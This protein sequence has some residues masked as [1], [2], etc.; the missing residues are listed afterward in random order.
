[1]SELILLC[2]PAEVDEVRRHGFRVACA[3]WQAGGDGRLWRCPLPELPRGSLMAVFGGAGENE[4]LGADIAAECG[5]LGIN[6]VLHFAEAPLRAAGG[7]KLYAPVSTAISGGSL[8]QRFDGEASAFIEPVREYFTLPARCGS[9]RQISAAQLEKFAAGACCSGF[10]PELGC[11]YTFSEAGCV[12][13]DDA[14]TVRRK[15]E[16]LGNIGVERIVLPYASPCVRE[17]LRE[18]R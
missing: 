3:A 14:E 12:L 4:R 10:S 18:C 17:F 5:R 6:E 8:S 16:L 7:Y 15:I 2:R 1:M 9:G 13:H 11:K